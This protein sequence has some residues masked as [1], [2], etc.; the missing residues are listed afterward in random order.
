MNQDQRTDQEM[1]L[2]Q[3]WRRHNAIRNR[4]LICEQKLRQCK[5]ATNRILRKK[6]AQPVKNIAIYIRER[7]MGWPCQQIKKHY[8]SMCALNK[9]LEMTLKEFEF[10][11]SS[12]LMN[13]D[14]IC[15]IHREISELEHE[16]Y[17]SDSYTD[18]D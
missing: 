13:R 10:H 2:A 1:R 7:E 17:L 16:M 12:F 5:Q 14:Q 9:I 11:F 8:T 6:K 18:S 4:M 15:D 3:L